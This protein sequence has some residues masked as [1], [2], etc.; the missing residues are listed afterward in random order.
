MRQRVQRERERGPRGRGGAFG[1][2]CGWVVDVEWK[3]KFESTIEIKKKPK[4]NE[5]KMNCFIHKITNE[6]G[7]PIYSLKLPKHILIVNI[8]AECLYTIIYSVNTTPYSETPVSQTL[9]YLHS[10][11]YLRRMND[12]KKKLIKWITVVVQCTE[13]PT[14]RSITAV[15]SAEFSQMNKWCQSN[16]RNATKWCDKC[17]SGCDLW[18]LWWIEKLR[19]F[20]GSF[21]VFGYDLLIQYLRMHYFCRQNQNK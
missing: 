13:S 10:T 7:R 4:L 19:T 18:H 16:K 2:G 5:I 9:A 12:S 11:I 21:S 1:S 6:I 3:M 8:T 20:F 14:R 17:K 15:H